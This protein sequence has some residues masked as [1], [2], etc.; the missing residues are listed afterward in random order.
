[1]NLFEYG[2]AYIRK[3]D[4]KDLAILKFCLCA[5]G[6]MIG[7]QVPEKYKK[8]VIAGSA[9]VFL[10]TYIPLMYKFFKVVREEIKQE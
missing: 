8:P 3:S 6:V 7:C 4:W 2:N 10:A 9:V 1:M 5:I